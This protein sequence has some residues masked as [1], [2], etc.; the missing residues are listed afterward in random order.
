MKRAASLGDGEKNKRICLGL[1]GEKREEKQ[2]GE[3]ENAEER[4]RRTRAAHPAEMQ[5]G[6]NRI[7]YVGKQEA[8]D[9]VRVLRTLSLRSA[10]R[11]RVY[12]RGGRVAFSRLR[13]ATLTHK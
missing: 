7:S 9:A 3:G 6:S 11:A 4:G 5:L 1:P 8:A 13:D 12:I 2:N 10:P